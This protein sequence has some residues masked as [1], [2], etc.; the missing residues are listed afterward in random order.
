LLETAVDCASSKWYRVPLLTIRGGVLAILDLPDS[1]LPYKLRKNT[2]MLTSESKC[3]ASPYFPIETR[4]TPT[5]WQ[6]LLRLF[7]LIGLL[8]IFYESVVGRVFQPLFQS[9]GNMH[10][11]WKLIKPSILWAAMG[12]TLLCFRTFLWFRYRPAEPADPYSAPRLTVIIPAYNEGP[13]VQKSIDSVAAADYPPNRLEIIVVDDGSTDDTWKHIEA[14]ASR[15]PHLLTP[16]RFPQ[17]R[18]KRAALETGIRRACGE[19]VVTIDSDSVIERQTLLSIA[20]PFRNPSVGA[21]AGKVLAYNRDKGIIPRMLHVRF[22]LSFDFLRAA[23]STYGTVYCC[24]GALS[25]YRTSVVRNVLD[26]WMAQ[27]FLGEQCTYGEDRA[28]TNFI[29]AE[30]YD[31]VYQRTAVVHTVVP[32]TYTKLAKMYLRWDRSYVKEEIRFASII[33]KRP[34]LARVIS[35]TDFLITNLR[36]PVNY[37]I[38][39]LLV[40]MSIHD[41]HTIL[42]LLTAIGLISSFHALYYLH[43]ERSWDFVYGIFYTYFAFFTLFWIFPTAVLTVRSRSWLTR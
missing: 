11:T 33:W 24:P 22:V 42:R 17:N 34:L 3:V 4:L 41:P 18:G 38:L 30:G 32:L 7:I 39:V 43:S 23:Q 2:L 8:I 25:A 14:A 10:W 28:L 13:M 29:L 35:F 16:I 36:Y 21:V 19:I 26:A 20:G 27:T 31:T 15:Y 37:L 1:L 40:V 5:S 9:A 12:M 6:W